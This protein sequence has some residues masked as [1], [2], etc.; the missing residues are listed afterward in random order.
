MVLVLIV[1][2]PSETSVQL[3]KKNFERMNFSWE[4]HGRNFNKNDFQIH[5]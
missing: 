1:L 4:N 2:S 5:L 3:Q